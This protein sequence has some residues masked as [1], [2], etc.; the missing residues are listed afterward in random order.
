MLV[1]VREIP[2]GIKI[3]RQKRRKHQATQVAIGAL[4]KVWCHAENYTQ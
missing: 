2:R 4:L 3:S 1:S